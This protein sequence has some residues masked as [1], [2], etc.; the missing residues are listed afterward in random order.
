MIQ[1]IWTQ[2]ISSLTRKARSRR[3]RNQRLGCAAAMLECGQSARAFL[4]CGRLAP[5]RSDSQP[6]S[7]ARLGPLLSS[8]RQIDAKLQRRCYAPTCQMRPCGGGCR[9]CLVL[10]DISGRKGSRAMA[11]REQAVRAAV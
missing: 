8:I 11:S 1:A 3:Q 4:S 9:D 7:L 10:V 6:K 5:C 2:F